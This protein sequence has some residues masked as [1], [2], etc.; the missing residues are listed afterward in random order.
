MILYIICHEF[1]Y[2]VL[3]AERVVYKAEN[4]EFVELFT[5][6]KSPSHDGFA[7]LQP[8]WRQNFSEFPV[9]YNARMY[10]LSFFVELVIALIV[11]RKIQDKQANSKQAQKDKKKK[12]G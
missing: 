12:D 10:V 3:N 2:G 4:S 8:R 11:T 7:I 6:Y 5:E 1:K 9:S